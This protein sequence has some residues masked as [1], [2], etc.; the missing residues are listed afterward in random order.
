MTARPDAGPGPRLEPVTPDNIDAAL[1]LSVRPDQQHAVAPV[2]RSLAEAYVHPDL[3][4]PRLIFDGEE[5]VGFLMA[6]FGAEFNPGEAPRDG[7]W[8]LNIA[9]DRQGRGYGRFAVES[10]AAEIRRRGGT[11]LT[12][13]WHPGPTGPEE[14]YLRLGFEKTGELS[15]DQIVGRLPLS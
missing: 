2:V 13:T 12:V 5:L 14:F 7:L 1:A 15:G 4:W 3:A 11:A 8:R 10:V 6:F 9:A